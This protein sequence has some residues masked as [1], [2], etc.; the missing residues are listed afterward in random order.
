MEVASCNTDGGFKH[1]PYRW[2]HAIEGLRQTTLKIAS[3]RDHGTDLHWLSPFCKGRIIQL[4]RPWT[5]IL[6][7]SKQAVNNKPVILGD[8]RNGTNLI[9]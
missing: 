2:Q 9:L 5:V 1:L 6:A 3:Y 4:P 8:R 7:L